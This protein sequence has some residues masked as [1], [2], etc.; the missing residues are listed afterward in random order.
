MRSLRRSSSL[1]IA[2][3]GRPS[4]LLESFRLRRYCR[5]T[6]SQD[7]GETTIV[8]P[9]VVDPAITH[10]RHYSACLKQLRRQAPLQTWQSF[11]KI[12]RAWH[13]LYRSL[14]QH[15]NIG[16]NRLMIAIQNGAIL[17]VCR[18]G[19]SRLQLCASVARWDRPPTCDG[20]E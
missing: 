3:F 5:S 1:S 4:V 9:L 20:L 15:S 2:L 18:T 16:T 6:T 14:Y 12:P 10:A 7:F 8:F 11:L 17:N 13:I 19:T